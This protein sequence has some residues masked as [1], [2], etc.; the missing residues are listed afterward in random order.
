MA[1]LDVRVC[2]KELEQ[3]SARVIDGFAEQAG[4]SGTNSVQSESQTG[5][6]GRCW[7]A[8]KQASCSGPVQWKH[9]TT[10]IWASEPGQTTD[11]FLRGVAALC[12]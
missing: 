7:W 10:R 6:A 5:A 2:G 1:I 3:L 12:V 8:K 9:Y 11:G 4:P